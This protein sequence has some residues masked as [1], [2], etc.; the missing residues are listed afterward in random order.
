M[1]WISPF[2]SPLASALNTLV[3]AGRN[4]A[5]EIRAKTDNEIDGNSPNIRGEGGT[6]T[7][8]NIAPAR[9]IANAGPATSWAMGSLDFKA[10]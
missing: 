4:R 6:E 9:A 2:P 10:V 7:S 5:K 8:E 3:G 1:K